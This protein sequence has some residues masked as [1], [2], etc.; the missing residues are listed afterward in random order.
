[1]DD[2]R[3]FGRTDI[4]APYSGWNAD[5]VNAKTYTVQS[6]EVLTIAPNDWL[7]VD[8]RAIDA[9]PYWGYSMQVYS[10][11]DDGLNIRKYNVELDLYEIVA[12]SPAWVMNV[13]RRV[14]A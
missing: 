2:V 4:Y 10:C 14:G 1:M 12:L 5:L 6:G 9:D 11:D 13:Y 3:D 7:D 8:D